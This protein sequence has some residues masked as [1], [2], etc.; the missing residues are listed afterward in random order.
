MLWK[1]SAM[2]NSLLSYAVE[3]TYHPTNSNP[4]EGIY[5]CCNNGNYTI[6]VVG[7]FKI[8]AAVD[9]YDKSIPDYRSKVE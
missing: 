2:D 3:S 1:G 4:M 7:S 9:A 5:I 8:V 6:P